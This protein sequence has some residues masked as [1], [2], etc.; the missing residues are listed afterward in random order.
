MTLLLEFAKTFDEQKIIQRDNNS[1][2]DISHIPEKFFEK[3]EDN[4]A[5]QETKMAKGVTI[6]TVLEKL[7]IVNGF[8]AVGAFSPNGEPVAEYNISGIDLDEIG[9]LANDVLLKAKKTAETM[10]LGQGQMIHIQAF[11]AHIIA[12]CLNEEEDDS[13]TDSDKAHVHMVII[14]KP[15]GNVAMAK[16]KL[17]S[18]I[19]EIAS[20]FK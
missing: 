5:N 1:A 11:K 17:E 12:R 6:E 8:L 18:V 19:K 15:N 20:F 2:N 3:N 10:E 14:L 4:I 9:G 16:I 7:S 13:V